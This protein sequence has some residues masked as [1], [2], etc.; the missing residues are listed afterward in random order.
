LREIREGERDSLAVEV[1]DVTALALGLVPSSEGE[2]DSIPSEVLV[3]IG[4]AR[5]VR[6]RDEGDCDSMDSTR[7]V[8]ESVG[9]RVLERLDL[10]RRRRA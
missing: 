9:R 6:A 8:W 2:R 10:S 7:E 3:R 5:E 1:A 4:R